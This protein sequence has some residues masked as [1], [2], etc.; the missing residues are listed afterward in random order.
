M[1][2]ESHKEELKALIHKIALDMTKEIL[3]EKNAD[4]VYSSDLYELQDYLGDFFVVNDGLSTEF[5]D[6]S[7]VSFKDL[8]Q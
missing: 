4:D 8:A 5:P 7:I 2:T 1:L 3:S 6:G